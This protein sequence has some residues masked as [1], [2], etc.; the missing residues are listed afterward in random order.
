MID[1]KNLAP[2]LKKSSLK[3][4]IKRM[5]EKKIGDMAK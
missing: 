4:K 3:K 2:I 5:S 1:Y